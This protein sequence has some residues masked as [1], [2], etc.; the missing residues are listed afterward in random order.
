MT[1]ALDHLK[2]SQDFQSQVGV[3]KK[4]T[5]IKITKPRKQQFIR[6]RPGKDWCI[7]A[8]L[9]EDAERELYLVDKDIAESI[10]DDLSPREIYTSITRENDLFLWAIKV[11]IDGKRPNTWN[12]SAKRAVEVAKEDW[13]RVSP[14]TKNGTYDTFVAAGKIPEPD[15][16]ELNFS[17]ILEIAFNER[18]ITD[19]NHPV[20]RRYRGEE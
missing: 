7:N 20:L 8:S 12:Q 5:T 4:I 15:W 17:Q 11:D 2:S 6:V 18:I 9:F 14:N 16:G 19:I 10:A 1:S 3:K 13:I